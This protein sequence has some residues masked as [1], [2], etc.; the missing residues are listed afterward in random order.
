MPH[1]AAPQQ[2]VLAWLMSKTRIM[3]SILGT[4]SVERLDGTVVATGGRL[5][6]QEAVTL[7]GRGPGPA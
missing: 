5:T 3:L 4:P 1:D 6:E 7:S 2:V